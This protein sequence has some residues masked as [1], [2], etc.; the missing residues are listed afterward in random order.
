[1]KKLIKILILFI[2]ALTL[3]QSQIHVQA[4]FKAIEVGYTYQNEDFLNFGVSVSAVDADIVE[5]RANTN[6]PY[7]KV[8]QLNSDLVPAVFGTVGA[9]FDNFTITGKMGAA[10]L[11]QSI[12]NV[13]DAQK[14][15][16]GIGIRFNYKFENNLSL[17]GGYDNIN[18][19]MLGIAFN[20]E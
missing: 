5:K 18:S 15:Y 8:H 9:T 1:M 4:G 10:Y 17:V 19:G 16:W 14:I 13:A 11:N 6:D 20:L 2:P 3:A 7:K 12:N